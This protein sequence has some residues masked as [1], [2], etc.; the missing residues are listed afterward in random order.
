MICVNVPPASGGGGS[1]LLGLAEAM[2]SMVATSLTGPGVSFSKFG[3]V[4]A[5]PVS[6]KIQ[7]NVKMND[8]IKTLNGI[9]N[10]V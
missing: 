6:S 5:H 2:A 10:K 7:I 4:E 3:P 1:K 8:R 9:Q